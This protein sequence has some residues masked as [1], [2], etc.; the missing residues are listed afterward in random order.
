VVLVVADSVVVLAAVD[1][2]VVVLAVVGKKQSTKFE[3][4]SGKF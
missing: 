3:V 2:L 1:S 4:R